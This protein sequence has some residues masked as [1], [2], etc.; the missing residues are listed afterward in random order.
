MNSNLALIQWTRKNFPDVYKAAVSKVQRKVA[1]GGL[2]DDLLSDISFDSST[3]DNTPSFDLSTDGA[4][5]PNASSSSTDWSGIISSVAQAIPTVASS[6]VSTQSQLALIHTNASLASQGKPLVNSLTNPGIAST[7]AGNSLLILGV[8]G[9]AAI[10]LVSS[11]RG[12][13]SKG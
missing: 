11:G 7:A 8:L 5:Q 1:F 4:N 6:I 13:S 10:A 3:I 9:I 12:A 2:G